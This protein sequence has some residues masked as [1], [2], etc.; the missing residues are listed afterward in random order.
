MATPNLWIHAL[1]FLWQ[2]FD[3]KRK[4]DYFITNF[5]FKKSKNYQILEEIC[6][7]RKF[8]HIMLTQL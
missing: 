1:F 2:K 5:Q 8:H 7:Q 3:L 6:F 4:K